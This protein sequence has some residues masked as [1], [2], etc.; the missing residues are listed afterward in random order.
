MARRPVHQPLRVLLNGR[1]V[2]LLQKEAAGSISFR[3]DARWANDS[4][5]VPVSL[6]LPLR[7]EPFW[8]APVQAV[9]ENL[10]PDSEQLRRAVA[11][12]VGAE[13]TDA[14]SLLSRI[15]RDCVGSLQFIPEGGE[16]AGESAGLSGEV[17]DERAVEVILQNLARTPLGLDPESEFRISIAGAQEKTALLRHEDKWIRPHGTTPTTH[18]F[19]TQ[20]GR[21]QNGMDLSNSVENEF[22]CMRLLKEF[23]LPVASAEIMRFGQTV[24]LVV[25]RFDRKWSAAGELNRLAQEDCCQALTFPSTKKYQ[26]AGGPGM[27]EILEL[28]K[29]SDY[30]R[31]DQFTF[32]R[33]QILFWLIGATDGHAKNFSVFL[34]PQGRF[35]LTPIYDVLSA[36]PSLARRQIEKK[37]MK[38][39]MS[40]GDRRHYRVDEI[41]GRHFVQ[42]AKGVGLA[43]SLA[44]SALEDVAA[45]VSTAIARAEEN[46]PAGFPKEIS[47][48]IKQSL[49]ERSARLKM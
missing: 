21:L 10:L 43:E 37:D 2:G 19:K 11:E 15:G 20:I 1:F 24:A 9:F 40:V 31:Q 8:G 22:F 34:G 14:F 45:R 26:N 44:K 12:R 32:L 7:N 49:V 46:L 5:A 23:E 38:L 16:P 39:A 17:L 13:G 29:S 42:T 3:Y 35:R 30:P 48:P 25:Q 41:E 47:E 36:Q 33:A 27:R 4:K 6:S 18:I 28:L